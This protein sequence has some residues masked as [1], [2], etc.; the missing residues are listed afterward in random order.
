MTQIVDKVAE[1][2][3]DRLEPDAADFAERLANSGYVNR[4]DLATMAVAYSTAISLKEISRQLMV[5]NADNKEKQ[6]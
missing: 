4:V 3:L 2:K 1:I 6:K 5:M